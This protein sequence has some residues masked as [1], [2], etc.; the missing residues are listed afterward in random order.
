VQT[1]AYRRPNRRLAELLEFSLRAAQFDR[2]VRAGCHGG[3]SE[4]VL[5]AKLR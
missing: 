5:N 3:V 2:V 4:I 1:T